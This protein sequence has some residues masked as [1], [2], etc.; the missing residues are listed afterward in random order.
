MP[1][2]NEHNV[3]LDRSRKVHAIIG[4]PGKLLIPGQ[5]DDLKGAPKLSHPWVA[6]EDVIA[7]IVE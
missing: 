4:L 7:L 3:H 1:E 5:Y 2:D 6:S